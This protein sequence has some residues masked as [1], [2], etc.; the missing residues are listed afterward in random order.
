MHS[1]DDFS[2]IQAHLQ[3]RIEAEEEEER[4]AQLAS[5]LQPQTRYDRF[6]PDPEGYV[7]GTYTRNRPLYCPD[8]QDQGH[9]PGYVHSGLSDNQISN[10]AK[11]VTAP[12]YS[13]DQNITQHVLS[14]GDT[15]YSQRYDTAEMFLPNEHMELGNDNRSMSMHSRSDDLLSEL[16]L[17]GGNYDDNLRL[18]TVRRSR[19]S[20]GHHSVG[21]GSQRSAKKLGTGGGR[22][23]EIQTRA[24][25]LKPHEV[26]SANWYHTSNLCFK[27]TTCLETCSLFSF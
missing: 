18:R 6:T 3:A 12:G 25:P 16:D 10:A 5:A 7:F 1:Q 23:A 17:G 14:S 24:R 2:E 20:T 21:S 11:F 8:N 26:S 19:F 27:R 9:G 4:H 13:Y 22:E 15:R